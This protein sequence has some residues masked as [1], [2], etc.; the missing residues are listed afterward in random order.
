M[1]YTLQQQI[2]WTDITFVTSNRSDSYGSPSGRGTWSWLDQGEQTGSQQ[3]TLSWTSN[4]TSAGRRRAARSSQQDGSAA[5]AAALDWISG[6]RVQELKRVQQSQD[7][8]IP[9]ASPRQGRNSISRILPEDSVH[10]ATSAPRDHLSLS[11]LDG[12]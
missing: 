1:L 12:Q 9:L 6:V 3:G 10:H 11:Q 7:S 5:E 4:V 2:S 8:S